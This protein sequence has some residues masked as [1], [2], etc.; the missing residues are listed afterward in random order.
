MKN[1]PDLLQETEV[2][3][4]GSDLTAYASKIIED[5]YN[6]KISM[7]EEQKTVE[8]QETLKVDVKNITKNKNNM[9]TNI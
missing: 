5:N 2:E 8:Y 6:M 3:N 1:N 9:E 7:K 4:S